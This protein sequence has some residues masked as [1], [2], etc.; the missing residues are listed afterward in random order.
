MLAC[1][2]SGIAPIIPKRDTPGGATR[3]VLTI[4]DFIYEPEH[5]RYTCPAGQHLTQAPVR[6]T[7]GPDPE[8]VRCRNFD[9]CGACP[10]KPRCTRTR[11]KQIKRW[12]HDRVLDAMQDRPER[13][14]DTMK[15]RR[16][17]VEHPLGTI[18]SWMGATHFLTKTLTK[19]QTE[20]S[21]QVLAC[22]RERMIAISG[23]GLLIQAIA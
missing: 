13:M 9:V 2:G 16:R 22:N 5:D 23:A 10:L 11:F 15:I 17:T 12:K 18:K 19:V 7:R 8:L 20:M 6:P 4:Q 21:L 14:P 1:E 3:G